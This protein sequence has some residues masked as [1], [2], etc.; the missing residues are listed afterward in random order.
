MAALFRNKR[1]EASICLCVFDKSRALTNCILS[2][3]DHRRRLSL[4]APAHD[5]HQRLSHPE[6]V[7]YNHG[8]DVANDMKQLIQ[9]IV[10]TDKNDVHH[11]GNNND[12][13]SLIMNI[14]ALAIDSERQDGNGIEV[15]LPI[16]EILESSAGDQSKIEKPKD[17]GE[18]SWSSP[19]HAFETSANVPASLGKRSIVQTDMGA[20]TKEVKRSRDELNDNV[21]NASGK[22]TGTANRPS[23]TTD[24]NS[25]KKPKRPSDTPLVRASCKMFNADL[26]STTRKPKPRETPLASAKGA[27]NMT[28]LAMLR[29][30]HEVGR[31]TRLATMAVPIPHNNDMDKEIEDKKREENMVKEEKKTTK[32]TEEKEKSPR[33][34]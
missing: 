2:E 24:T 31:Q 5:H 34:C 22:T 13:E 25:P 21:S 9:E 11:G 15:D 14:L 33:P 26:T 27:K 6:S 12:L 20:E 28:D 10:A 29:K 16:Q 18:S 4:P 17:A 8:S 3:D 1:G 19:T 30:E 7:N 23:A 32:D